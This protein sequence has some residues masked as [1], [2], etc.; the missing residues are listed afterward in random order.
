MQ[1]VGNDDMPAESRPVQNHPPAKVEIKSL[2]QPPPQEL[3]QKSTSEVHQEPEKEVESE[4]KDA[5]RPI[6]STAVTGTPWCVVWTGDGRVFFF[7]PSKRVSV[8]E[9]P[10]ELK[11]RTDVE[12]LLEKPPKE[13]T[14]VEKDEPKPA[15][16]SEEPVS[17]RAR[18]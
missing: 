1:N 7:N 16:V 15:A 2:E 14:S 5:S 3:V 13:S 10:D 4:Q 11:G 6:S 9:T 12:R 8:W 18:M 17:K